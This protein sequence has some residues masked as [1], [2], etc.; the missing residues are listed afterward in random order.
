MSKLLINAINNRYK[1][2]L[3]ENIA[4]YNDDDMPVNV[5]DP[6]WEHKSDSEKNF[7]F[8]SYTI[9]DVKILRYF[10]GEILIL[11]HKFNHHPDI[12]IF[13]NK[14]DIKLFTIDMYDVS[15]VDV[16]M[17]KEID[18]IINDLTYLTSGQG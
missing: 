17:S 9:D 15:H 11:S 8:R 5:G 3:F 18:K 14:V 13:N 12:N 10:I 16:E 2:N 7:L 4:S 6:G 1:G